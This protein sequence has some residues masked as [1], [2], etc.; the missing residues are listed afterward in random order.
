MLKTRDRHSEDVE[1][2]PEMAEYFLTLNKINR[3]IRT[4]HIE[5]LARQM[6]LGMWHWTDDAIRFD[7]DG[8]L[9]DG[10]HRCKA[11]IMHGQPV[12]CRVSYGIDPEAQKVMD[13][14]AKRSASDA[15]AL[16]NYS[17]TKNL[18]SCARIMIMEGMGKSAF[19]GNLEISNPEI[20]DLVEHKHP[21]LHRFI[22]SPGRLP[23]GFAV[24][25]ISYINYIGNVALG[26]H[27]KTDRFIEILCHGSDK[28][29]PARGFRERVL[30]ALM[31]NKKLKRSIFWFSLK[32]AYVMTLQDKNPKYFRTWT[33]EIEIPGVTREW[34][35][36][37]PKRGKYVRAN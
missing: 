27:D 5:N 25:T 15:L 16:D 10:Q 20:V 4:G 1:V 35:L 19:S 9:I 13:S 8:N 23:R 32:K 24:S 26:E 33:E 18:A 28:N 2:T 31:S 3:P 30:D 14:G 37:G 7:W 21:D 6:D 11:I 29:H 22:I 17:N 12:L 36:N 34:L